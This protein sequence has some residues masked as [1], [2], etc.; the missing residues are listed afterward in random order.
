MVDGIQLHE[1]GGVEVCTSGSRRG[2]A[3]DCHV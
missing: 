1:L 3:R 2:V